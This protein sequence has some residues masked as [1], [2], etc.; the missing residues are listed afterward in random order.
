MIDVALLDVRSVEPPAE[1]GKR[2]VLG[3]FAVEICGVTV[4]RCLLLKE[5]HRRWVVA[6]RC[7][8]EDAE[9][10]FSPALNRYL[11]RIVGEALEARMETHDA[12][13]E[14]GS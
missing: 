14:G 5:V 3:S 9:V 10:R 8:H 13:T 6:P 12:P 4:R 11:T 7:H 1:P 2:L